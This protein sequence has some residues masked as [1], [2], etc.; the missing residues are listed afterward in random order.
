M[1]R[2][3]VPLDQVPPRLGVLFW[4]RGSEVRAWSGQRP[5]RVT[6]EPLENSWNNL[7]T[8]V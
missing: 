6:Q 4:P 8:Q 5:D 7:L 1:Y 3:V 2:L